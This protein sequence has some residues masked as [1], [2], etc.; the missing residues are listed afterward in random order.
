MLGYYGRYFKENGSEQSNSGSNDSLSGNLRIPRQDLR[1]MMIRKLK[2][3]TLQWGM[4]ILDYRETEDYVDID[5]DCFPN[6]NSKGNCS[7]ARKTV[8]THLLV[9]ADGIGS[10]V[11][12]LRDMKK[13]QQHI[14]PLQYTGVAAMI[15]ISSAISPL[16]DKRGF[17][18][19]DGQH[20][21]FTMPF[22]DPE[23]TK[24]NSNSSQL[25]PFDI[26]KESQAK[27]KIDTNSIDKFVVCEVPLTMWQLSFAADIEEAKALKNCEQ[28]KLIEIAT[29]RTASWFDPVRKLIQSTLEG[30]VWATPLYDRDAMPLKSKSEKGSRVTCIGDACHPMSMF[31]VKKTVN[32]SEY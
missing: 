6:E 20:R 21:L 25:T 9:G 12:R 7:N 11:R 8:R 14:A 26:A 5:F 4:K 28:E 16:L 18:V 10:I 3:G 1:Y 15:G 2:K 23:T 19:L 27:Y 30:E 13:E 31:K 22:Y 17:Y 24:Q 29:K 32:L